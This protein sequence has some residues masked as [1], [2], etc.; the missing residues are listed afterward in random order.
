MEVFIKKIIFLLGL[1]T[2]A[3]LFSS[4]ITLPDGHGGSYSY[5]A[6]ENEIEYKRPDGSKMRVKQDGTI[7]RTSL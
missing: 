7:S 5:P 1:L 4:C 6:G 2:T 3:G